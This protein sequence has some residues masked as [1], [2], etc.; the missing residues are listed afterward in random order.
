MHECLTP[1]PACQRLSSLALGPL[2]QCALPSAA[3]APGPLV[4]A[5]RPWFSRVGPC[6]LADLALDF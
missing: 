1:W 4:S 3:D 2:G 6:N 5:R